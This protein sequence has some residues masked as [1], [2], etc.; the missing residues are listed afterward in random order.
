M[1]VMEPARHSA[2]AQVVNPRMSREEID[3]KFSDKFK[4]HKVEELPFEKLEELSL[5]HIYKKSE[6]VHTLFED[7]NRYINVFPNDGHRVTLQEGGY[8][9]VSPIY[10]GEKTYYVGQAPTLYSLYS[11]QLF[12]L[13]PLPEK[14]K[15]IETIV[16]LTMPKE[17]NRDTCYPY[18]SDSASIRCVKEEVL[19]TEG[20]TQIVHRVLEIWKDGKKQKTIHQIAVKNWPDG[21]IVSLNLLT[22]LIDIVNQYKGGKFIHCSAG[23]GRSGVFLI[24]YHAFLHRD[25]ETINESIIRCRLQRRGIVQTKE[26]HRYLTVDV[27]KLISNFKQASAT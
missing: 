14:P 11:F 2:A 3:N 16:T 21:S 22:K 18:W 10:L 6:V 15:G 26:Q 1:Q 19:F 20:S 13:S 23:L 7:Q 8:L 12:L 5:T 27:R 17:G 24:A 25:Y 9:N 4:D